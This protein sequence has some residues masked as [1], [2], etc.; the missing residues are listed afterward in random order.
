MWSSTEVVDVSVRRSLGD[1]S[2]RGGGREVGAGELQSRLLVAKLQGLR[3]QSSLQQAI[4][5]LGRRTARS[6]TRRAPPAAR[7]R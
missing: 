2:G 3:R 5:E 7:R 6:A 1:R 4:Q